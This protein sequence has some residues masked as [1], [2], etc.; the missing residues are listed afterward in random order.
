MGL[1]YVQYLADMPFLIIPSSC[2]ASILDR[3]AQLAKCGFFALLQLLA[4]S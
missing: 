4:Q 2:M 3:R 1:W